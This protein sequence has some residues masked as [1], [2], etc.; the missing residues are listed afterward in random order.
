MS[1]RLNGNTVPLTA[2][3]LIELIKD[4]SLLAAVR[5]ESMSVMLINEETGIRHIDAQRLTNL[6]LMQSLYIEI[7]RL[8][9]S[10]NPMRQAVRDLDIDDYTIEKGALV[11]TCSQIAHQ[12]E[13]VWGVKGH[14]ASK[15]WAWRHLKSVD[16]IGN[17]KAQQQFSMAARPSSFFPYGMSHSRIAILAQSLHCLLHPQAGAM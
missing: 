6:P 2:W 16:K 12:E 13:A 14:P 15:F 11:Q 7:M 17:P 1:S 3:M 5:E 9:V 4:P 10:F 8:H